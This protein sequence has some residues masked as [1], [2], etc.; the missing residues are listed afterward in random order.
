M[1]SIIECECVSI[2]LGRRNNIPEIRIVL[3]GRDLKDRD[4]LWRATEELQGR[5]V[6]GVS[7]ER[8]IAFL[9]HNQPVDLVVVDLDE[10]G[11]EVLEALATAAERGL[12][13]RRVLGYFSHVQETTGAAARAAGV[14]AY[15]RSRFWRELPSLLEDAAPE[16]R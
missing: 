9:T 14:E 16:Q 10:G 11:P 6:A 1:P 3:I 13:P 4:R 8:A 15:P 5:T 2:N 12:L 7:A